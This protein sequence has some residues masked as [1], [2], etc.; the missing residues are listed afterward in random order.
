M[1]KTK[2]FSRAK[3]LETFYRKLSDLAFNIE[4]GFNSKLDAISNEEKVDFFIK[5][6]E[7]EEARMCNF[8]SFWREI[9]HGEDNIDNPLFFVYMRRSFETSAIQHILENQKI[10]NVNY[11]IFNHQLRQKAFGSKELYKIKAEINIKTNLIN[12]YIVKS[13]K[14]FFLLGFIDDFS[15]PRNVIECAFQ[16]ENNYEKTSKLM[17]DYDYLGFR[18]HYAPLLAHGHAMTDTSRNPLFYEEVLLLC[19]DLKKEFNPRI[20]T[21]PILPISY[22][23]ELT[24]L[25]IDFNGMVHT[26]LEIFDTLGYYLEY[27][28]LLEFLLIID[29]IYYCHINNLDLEFLPMIKIFYEKTS[30]L[31]RFY[32][33]Y[34]FGKRNGAFADYVDVINYGSSLFFNREDETLP[35]LKEVY[36]KNKQSLNNLSF[37]LFLSRVEKN[38]TYIIDHRMPNFT[39]QVETF[40]NK[41]NKEKAGIYFN[42]FVL[43][44][45]MTHPNG[46][47]LRY[48][49]INTGNILKIFLEAVSDI[50]DYFIKYLEECRIGFAFSAD[51]EDKGFE[52]IIRKDD[53]DFKAFA[54]VLIDELD[55]DY[56]EV[57]DINMNKVD[58]LDE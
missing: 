7:I 51:K 17:R 27:S 9:V 41:V 18:L 21:P 20:S 49:N 35:K 34:S 8:A 16:E 33:K 58:I 30:L 24:D 46:L 31:S 28:T 2:D 53:F 38:P 23:K 13:T 4:E 39:T 45:N 12:E 29:N 15:K 50:F 6:Q 32:E 22:N 44:C 25:Y 48:V 11:K 40:L 14:P 10:P 54:N 42:T 43:S 52:K 26:T 57:L 37:D 3:K 56:T 36:E 1:A 47:S 5:H 55:V 19:K